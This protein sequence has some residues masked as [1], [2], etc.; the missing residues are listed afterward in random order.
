[1]RALEKNVVVKKNEN[2]RTTTGGIIIPD[3]K[4]SNEATVLDIGSAVPLGVFKIGDVIV[5][6]FSAQL[7]LTKTDEGE[8]VA[9]VDYEDIVAVK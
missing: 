7:T 6:K 3:G 4:I 1:M 2:G 5:L 8:E 9:V